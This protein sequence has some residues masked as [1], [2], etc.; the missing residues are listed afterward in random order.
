MDSTNDLLLRAQHF[1]TS[2]LHLLDEANAP[3]DIGAHVDLAVSRLSD[4]LG[5]ASKA[6]H[7][8]RHS[9]NVSSP[10]HFGN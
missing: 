7:E 6:C 1:L 2:A 10:Q 9:G 5:T 3:A 4:E 8:L